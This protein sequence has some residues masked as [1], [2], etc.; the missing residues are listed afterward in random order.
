MGLKLLW[1]RQSVSLHTWRYQGPHK[2]SS[3]ATFMLNTGCGR[4]ATGQK[5][6]VSLDSHFSSVQLLVTLQ[7]VAWQAS[8]SGKGL[9]HAK[10]LVRIG[11]YWLAYPS[12]ALYFLLP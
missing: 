3:Y 4:A 8:L 11:Q 12:R 2:S 1:Q 5:S 6:L 10:I 7:T 9:L